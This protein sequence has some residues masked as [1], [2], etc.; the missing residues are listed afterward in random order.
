MATTSRWL[1][2]ESSGVGKNRSFSFFFFGSHDA[3]LVLQFELKG[4]GH[5][6]GRGLWLCSPLPFHH[7]GLG[8]GAENF[9]AR[10]T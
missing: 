9:R 6:G 10:A 7:T 8:G 5:S 1:Q 3:P 4:K 2:V